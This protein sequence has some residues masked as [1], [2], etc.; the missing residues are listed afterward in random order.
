MNKID[1]QDEKQNAALNSA[2]LTLSVA[3]VNY[4]GDLGC[5]TGG[6]TSDY[7]DD[8]DMLNVRHQNFKEDPV[9]GKVLA[10]LQIPRANPDLDN[11]DQLK[12]D[13]RR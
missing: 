11:S 3:V 6:I 8:Y 13:F 2:K 12:I 7:R 10:K 9:Y 4:Y 5:D 1:F